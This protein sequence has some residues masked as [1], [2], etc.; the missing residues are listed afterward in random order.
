MQ[1]APAQLVARDGHPLRPIA[2]MPR[3]VMEHPDNLGRAP[4]GRREGLKRVVALIRIERTVLAA[5]HGLESMRTPARPPTYRRGRQI[6]RSWVSQ[7]NRSS[8]I[9]SGPVDDVSNAAASDGNS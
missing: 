7:E 4:A 1:H 2:E 8:V 6:R 9:P 3:H 5:E